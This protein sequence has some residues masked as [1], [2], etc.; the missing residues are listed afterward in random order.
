LNYLKSI[1]ITGLP[2][3]M[4][5]EETEE[6]DTQYIKT[7]NKFYDHIKNIENIDQLLTRGWI[8]Q[9]SGDEDLFYLATNAYVN[10]FYFDKLLKQTI[11]KKII[12]IAKDVNGVEIDASYLKYTFSEK[13]AELAKGWET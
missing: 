11:G 3:Y 7:L 5:N 6:L 13:A 2:E 9:I 8:K 10:I 4:F 12:D 1:G